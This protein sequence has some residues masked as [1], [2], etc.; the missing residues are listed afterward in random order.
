MDFVDV[1]LVF[2]PYDLAIVSDDEL[3]RERGVR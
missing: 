3:A 1:D 2:K